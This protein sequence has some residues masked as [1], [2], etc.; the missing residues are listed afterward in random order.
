[1]NVD[2]DQY[3]QG[4]PGSWY[5]DIEII[6][7]RTISGGQFFY[8]RDARNALARRIENFLDDPQSFLYTKREEPRKKRV[9]RVI[10][11]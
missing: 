1:M 9:K 8:K 10:P 7:G 2:L 6:W 11:V 4:E 3:I 5:F